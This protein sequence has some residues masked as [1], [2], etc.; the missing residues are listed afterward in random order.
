MI[1]LINVSVSIGQNNRDRIMVQGAVTWDINGV[2]QTNQLNLVD[3][4]LDKDPARLIKLQ[5]L[6]DDLVSLTVTIAKNNM[7]IDPGI[8]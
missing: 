6:L 8:I 5:N 3:L 4:G 7:V 2:T 1:K